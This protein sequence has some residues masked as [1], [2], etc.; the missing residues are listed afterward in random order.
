MN[1]SFGGRQTARELEGTQAG[2]APSRRCRGLGLSARS[3]VLA[4]VLMALGSVMIML[5][6]CTTKPG[7]A[8]TAASPTAGTVTPSTALQATAGPEATAAGNVA[9]EPSTTATAGKSTAA[10]AKKRV[11]VAR[12]AVVSTARKPAA[13]AT[14]KRGQAAQRMNRTGAGE[15]TVGA[16]AK[17]GKVTEAVA[18]PLAAKPAA[19]ATGNGKPAAAWESP[20]RSLQTSKCGPSGCGPAGCP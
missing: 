9:P 7:A 2:S 4:G 13:A 20:L 3:A 11:R 10:V 15:P 1:G 5:P 6:G 17:Q 19:A 14:K 12:P 16:A 8:T 18:L